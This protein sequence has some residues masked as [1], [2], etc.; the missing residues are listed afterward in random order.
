MLIPN[1]EAYLTAFKEFRR[2]FN[3]KPDTWIARC[4]MRFDYVTEAGVNADKAPKYRVELSQP[5]GDKMGGIKAYT[6]VYN[7]PFPVYEPVEGYWCQHV[8]V[9]QYGEVDAPCTHIG[10]VILLRLY[11]KHLHLQELS[12]KG[13]WSSGQYK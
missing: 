2:L 8:V 13:Q 7:P 10:A 11:Q 3:T 12:A 6:V 1:K 4:E 5:L 9:S